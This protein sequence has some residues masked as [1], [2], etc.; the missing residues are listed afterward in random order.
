MFLKSTTMAITEIVRSP[1]TFPYINTLTSHN[2]IVQ[3]FTYNLVRGKPS[4]DLK[5]VSLT[6]NLIG[7]MF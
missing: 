6:K 2:T 7:V 5:M 4:L 3:I 1:S